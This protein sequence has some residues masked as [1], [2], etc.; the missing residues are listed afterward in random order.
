MS[1]ITHLAIVSA[2]AAVLSGCSGQLVVPAILPGA[3]ACHGLGCACE[4]PSDCQSQL[5]CAGGRCQLAMCSS[6][7]PDGGCPDGRVCSDGVCVTPDRAPYC[8]CT[9]T[10]GCD[11]GQCIDITTTTGCSPTLSLIHI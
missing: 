5:E 10:Q 6:W 8:D 11:D 2:A 1:R 3:E 9:P 7:R 4:K